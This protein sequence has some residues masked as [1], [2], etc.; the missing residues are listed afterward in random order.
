[1]AA[2]VLQAEG[3]IAANTSGSLTVTLPSKLSDDILILGLV[4]WGPNTTGDAAQIPT[5]TGWTLIGSQIGQPAG[6]RDG[7]VAWFW[8]RAISAADPAD[9]VCARGASWD[10]G[11]DTCFAGRAYVIRGCITTGDPW[12]AQA[13]A[14]P[15]TTANQAVA[16]VTVS[17]AERMV[18]QFFNEMDNASAGGI[19]G[20]TAGTAATSATGTDAGFQTFRKDN[21]SMSTG[22]DASTAA[23]PAQG[24]YAYMGLSFKPPSGT[25]FFQTLAST[26]VGVATLAPVFVAVKALIATAVGVAGLSRIMTFVSTLAATAIGVASLVK[27]ISKTLAAVATGAPDLLK[28]MPKTLA[29]TVIGLPALTQTVVIAVAMP[30]TAVGVAGL[31]KVLVV[32]RTMAGTAL[33]VASLVASFI[34][35]AVTVS[36]SPA[37]WFRAH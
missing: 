18:V 7:W 27:T 31:Q 25:T 1:M 29:A 11:T 2:P 14:G 36:S 32:V 33:G 5:P 16:A 26:A 9:P 22:A 8:R 21:V 4:Y 20:W 28:M 23:A 6:T 10:T 15:Y 24:A 34:A 35:G 13:A 30:A 17:D 3:A 37:R 12:D 19:S